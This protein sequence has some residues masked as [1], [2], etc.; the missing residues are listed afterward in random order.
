M[1]VTKEFEE[2]LFGT[3]NDCVDVAP[4]IVEIHVSSEE[5]AVQPETP[6][7]RKKASKND[8]TPKKTKSEPNTPQSTPRTT[9]TPRD[10]PRARGNKIA[11]S[12]DELLEQDKMLL[13]WKDV[14]LRF[15]THVITKD[16]QNTSLANLG[17]SSKQNGSGSRARSLV[18]VA[19][20]CSQI[21]Y[22]AKFH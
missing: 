15:N 18:S 6:K 4:P 8:T 3:S 9:I 14:S 21:E 20:I 22:K 5:D 19:K 10:T 17:Q 12:R 2:S 7:K 13:D 16:T 1:D 11:E